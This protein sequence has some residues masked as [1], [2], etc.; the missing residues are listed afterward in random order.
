MLLKVTVLSLYKRHPD[1]E[2]GKEE[3]IHPD[4]SINL[5]RIPTNNGAKSRSVNQSMKMSTQPHS[6][7]TEVKQERGIFSLCYGKP[8]TDCSKSYTLSMRLDVSRCN[9]GK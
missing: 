4:T 1:Q 2:G 6:S 9:L 3:Q 7:D 5:S 8:D